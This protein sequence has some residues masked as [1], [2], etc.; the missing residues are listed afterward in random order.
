MNPEQCN[1]LIATEV[2]KWP[3]KYHT[4]MAVANFDSYHNLTQA[5]MALSVFMQQRRYN[6]ELRMGF[7]GENLLVFMEEMTGYDCG[8][9]IIYGPKAATPSAAICEAIAEAVKGE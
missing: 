9:R 6:S 3:D 4:V 7:R 2:M 1:R 8:P 5:H